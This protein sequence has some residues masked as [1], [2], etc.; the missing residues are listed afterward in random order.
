MWQTISPVSE[1]RGGGLSRGFEKWQKLGTNTGNQ[2]GST[3]V[4]PTVNKS[5]YYITTKPAQKK[6]HY[7][8]KVVVFKKFDAESHRWKR[9]YI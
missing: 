3:T 7:C 9:E 5:N 6:K 4:T 2:S 1:Q 8:Q